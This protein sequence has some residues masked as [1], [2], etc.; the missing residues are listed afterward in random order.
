MEAVSATVAGPEILD[1]HAPARL[2]RGSAASPFPRPVLALLPS[3]AHG[4]DPGGDEP[5]ICDVIV[6]WRAAERELAAWSESDPEWRVAE[7]DIVW[8]RALHHRLFDAKLARLTA[9]RLGAGPTAV[10]AFA[11]WPYGVAT[12]TVPR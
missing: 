4:S 8:L 6:A 11:N 12:R 5:R 7:A 9:P 2:R 10:L 1:D 3:L